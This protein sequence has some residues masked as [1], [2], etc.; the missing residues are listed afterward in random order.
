MSEDVGSGEDLE[1]G[2]EVLAKEGRSR[3]KKRSPAPAG[4]LQPVKLCKADLYKPPTNE[5]LSQLK[6]TENLF[7]SNILRLQVGCLCVSSGGISVTEAGSC[8]CCPIPS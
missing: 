1:G 3:G 6:E 2:G 5:E 8:L 7:H 4:L